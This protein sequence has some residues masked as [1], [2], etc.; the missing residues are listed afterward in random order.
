[1][2]NKGI[3]AHLKLS[4]CEGKAASK[5]EA[6]K[7]LQNVVKAK[8]KTKRSLAEMETSDQSAWKEFDFSF[9]LYDSFYSQNFF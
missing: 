4:L 7:R 8:M 2:M 9:I 3:S 1:M 6:D 5:G